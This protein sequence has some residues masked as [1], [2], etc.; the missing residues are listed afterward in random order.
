[1]GKINMEPGLTTSEHG[2]SNNQSIVRSPPHAA[3]L[4]L[5]MNGRS[6]A[7]GSLD[8]DEGPNDRHM[9]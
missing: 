8:R 1:M 4:R 5:D 6:P 9:S 2:L 3:R 7:R